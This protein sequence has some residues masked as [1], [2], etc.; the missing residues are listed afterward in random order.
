MVSQRDAFATIPTITGR[1]DDEVQAQL[2]IIPWSQLQSKS[3]RYYLNTKMRVSM[4]W[5]ASL[6]TITVR[7]GSSPMKMEYRLELPLPAT[8]RTVSNLAYFFPA[9]LPENGQTQQL[10]CI[11]P[12]IGQSFLTTHSYQKCWL[13]RASG[14][15]TGRMTHS[16]NNSCSHS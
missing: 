11:L 9:L 10:F 13:S 8:T 12:G 4:S 2:P 3:R 7:T 5:I 14:T 6:Q 15:L 16:R 1:E